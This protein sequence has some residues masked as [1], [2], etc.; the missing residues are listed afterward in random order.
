M[1]NLLLAGFAVLLVQ[2]CAVGVKHDYQTPLSLDVS[3]AAPVAVA[4]LDNRPYI[5]DGQKTPNFVGLSRGGFGNPFDVTT[6]SG[7]PLASDMSNAIV[8]SMKGKGVNAKTVELKPGTPEAQALN[9]LR[10]AGAQR[11]VLLTLREWKGD[12]M[13]NVGFG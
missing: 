7:Q 13:V 10:A 5:V 4:T 2:G 3:T 6:Q 8:I 1:R 9:Q 12:S 11:S